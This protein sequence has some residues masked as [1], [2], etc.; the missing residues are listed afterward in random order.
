MTSQP[1]YPFGHGLSYTRFE[2]R[3]LRVAPDRIDAGGRSTIGA[4][5]TNAGPLA[6]DE[7]VQ[8]YVRYP[9]SAVERPV[10]E[11]KGFARVNLAPG[12]AKDVTFELPA[13]ELAYWGGAGWLIEPGE[14]ELLLG[15]SSQDIRLTGRLAVLPAVQG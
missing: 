13:S 3:N 1:L 14:V 4:T 9:H 10:R 12:D 6:G 7:V 2:Y 8:L 11:L 5:I 15:A